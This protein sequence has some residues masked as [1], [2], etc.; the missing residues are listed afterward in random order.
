M[1]GAYAIASAADRIIV[2]RTGYVGS[3]GV[4]CV[5]CDFSKAIEDRGMKVTIMQYGDAKADGRPEIP[6]S[7]EAKA[8]FQ[9]DID[10]MGRLFDATV[11]RNLGI[12]AGTVRGFQ[13]RTFMGAEGVSAGLAH[14]VLAPDEAFRGMIAS[15]GGY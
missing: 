7:K 10:A 15:V 2:P 11:A 6:L 3:I 14:E 12:S 4:V 5:H 13:A 8:R 9:A 1:S